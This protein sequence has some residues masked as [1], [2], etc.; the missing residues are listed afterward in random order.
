MKIYMFYTN[1]D[2]RDMEIISKEYNDLF[3]KLDISIE[4]IEEKWKE[5]EFKYSDKKKKGDVST[6]DSSYSA[7]FSEKATEI[8]KPYLEKDG[9]FLPINC[10]G[11]KYYIYHL[12]KRIDILDFEKS[13]FEYYDETKTSIF[14]VSK[15][16]FKKEIEDMSDLYIFRLEKPFKSQ[17]FITD[18]FENLVKKHNLKG[19]EFKFIVWDNEKTNQA[20]KT[21][22]KET[23]IDLLD[24]V[25]YVNEFSKENINEQLT[26]E[27]GITKVKRG[28]FNYL[29]EEYENMVCEPLYDLIEDLSMFSYANFPKQLK[30][31]RHLFYF[32]NI[33]DADGMSY[34]FNSFGDVDILLEGAKEIYPKKLFNLIK[35]VAKVYKKDGSDGNFDKLEDK[36]IKLVSEIDIEEEISNYLVKNVDDF[37]TKDS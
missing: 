36:Y 27:D 12:L 26:V 24:G 28:Y 4:L 20:E 23:K 14:R 7:I 32:D 21:M 9:E 10:K 19:F 6:A 29:C 25:N 8:L 35:K 1:N 34:F 15:Y 30:Y 11:D 5:L 33:T 22:E 37:C 18:K 17:I 16:E 13:E 2:F 3:D 31:L